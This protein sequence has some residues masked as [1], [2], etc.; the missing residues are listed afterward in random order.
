M[1]KLLKILVVL[2]VA[3]VVYGVYWFYNNTEEVENEK[4]VG[5]QGE[6]KLKPY[7][8]LQR[9]SEH[10]M[11]YTEADVN[12][13]SWGELS[14]DEILFIPLEYIPTDI[15]IFKDLENWLE[16]GGVLITG[17]VRSK[18]DF[19]VNFSPMHHRLI[20]F[21]NVEGENGGQVNLAINSVELQMPIAFSFELDAY[22]EEFR[23]DMDEFVYGYKTLGKGKIH[24][25]NSLR[26]FDN[27]NI[28]DKD[29]ADFFFSLINRDKDLVLATRPEYMGVW[30]WIKT[31]ARM[32]LVLLIICILVWLLMVSKRFGP[33]LLDRSVNS[34]KIMEHIQVSGEYQWRAKQSGLLVGELRLSI[35]EQ[36]KMRHPQS[37]RLSGM[38]Q[39]NYLAELSSVTNDN[40]LQS[41][42]GH[43]KT[44]DQFFKTV[45]ILKQIKDSL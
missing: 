35:Q 5:F 22:D 15:S 16:N 4:Y 44:P 1:S 43:C 23:T 29:N 39:N 21:K 32:S 30:S 25:F 11:S 9:L 17:S 42:T 10:V 3:V 28:R 12:L 27:R 31:R 20:G 8:A 36:M 7:L 18:N 41:M 33:L 38:E 26:A 37:N 24:L 19:D 13:A 14:R 40:V 6:A 45:T 34:R 2:F